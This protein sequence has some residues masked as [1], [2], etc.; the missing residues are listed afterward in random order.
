MA[1]LTPQPPAALAAWGVPD[2]LSAQGAGNSWRVVKGASLQADA[3][4]ELAAGGQGSVEYF[5][6]APAGELAGRGRV[7][8]LS[9]QGVGR[10]KVTA[11]DG[12]GRPLASVGWVFTGPL[13]AAGPTAKWLDVRY[14]ANYV[15]DWQVFD[16]DV[17]ALLAAH[18]PHAAAQAARYRLSVEVG[19]GQHALI[20]A[21][22]LANAPAKAV[23]VTPAAPAAA[24]LG[25]MVTV[26]AEVENVTARPL[27]GVTVELVEP[28][29][30]G[31]AAEGDKARTVAALGPG[32]K[33]R[34][35]WQVRAQRPDAVNFGQPWTVGF[36]VNGTAVPVSARVAVADPRPGKVFYVMTDD[37]E[38]IDSAGYP[39]AWGD[40]DG[41]LQPRELTVQMVDKAA[42]VNAI[43]EKYGA[44]WTHYIAWPLVAAADWAAGQSAAGEWR[45]AAEAIRQAVREQAGRGH[46]YALHLHSDY[47]PFLPGNVLSYNPAVDGLWA[48]HL[49]HGWAHSLGSEGNYNDYASRTGFLYAYQ[50]QL[51]ELAATSPHGQLITAR[52]GSFDFGSGPADEAMSTRV[53]R[54]VGLKAGSDADG[55]QGGVTAG[56]WG[57]AIYLARGDDINTPANDLR[58]AG[59]VQFR[60]TPRAFIQY[61]S[62]SAAAMNAKV[63]EGMA[64]YAPGGRVR[65]GV[66]AVVGFTHVMFIMGQGDWRSLEGGQFSALDG[67]LSYLKERY[68]DRGLLAFATA[69]ELVRAYLDYHAPVLTAV[70]GPRRA[71]GWLASEYPVVLLGRDIPV[72]ADRPHRV[73]LKY[74]L[75]LRD[76]AFR[77]SVLKNGQPIYTTWGLP[78]P[79][80]D[81]VFTVDDATA[82]YAL[83]VYHNDAAARLLVLWRTVKG[84]LGVG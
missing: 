22:T 67:H 36:A 30:F 33:A 79:E 31:L 4:L 41:W 46:E 19:Q 13:P 26:A 11:L 78:T 62:Q 45:T 17:A 72:G 25:D 59:L 74:P 43:A 83:K 70:Y 81:I 60:P 65:P 40:G 23:K 1:G 7:Q 24:V 63:D 49:R 2:S 34:L 77:I 29:G 44:K 76:S 80:N 55:N 18:A 21:L 3:A 66:H 58:M 84:R 39:V 32:E 14:T 52:V 69:G 56:D 64:H 47:D 54:R 73:T 42:K 8:F 28:Y 68:A 12:S 48:N 57:Q 61:D 51:D 16:H 53:Y 20:T 75:Y 15:G 5:R 6:E 50:R 9:T 27:A 37:L 71:A 35:S 82:Q 38:A 10:I